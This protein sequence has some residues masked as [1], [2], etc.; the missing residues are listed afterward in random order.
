MFN[1]LTAS[2][3]YAADQLFATLDPTLRR[4]QVED[5]GPV[6]V[7]DTV[8]FIRHLPHKLVESFRAT[9]EEAVSSDLLVHVIDC[10]D[11][12]RDDHNRQ[13]HE[14][15]AEIGA[16]ELPMLEVY[17]KID[18]IGQPPRIERNGEGRPVRVWLSARRANGLELLMEALSELLVG[19]LVDTDVVLSPDKSRLRSRLFALGGVQ[20]EEY[21]E[22]GCTCLLYTSD[23]ADE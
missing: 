8:G 7:A 6:V 22:Q 16:D 9:L 23:A 20:Q 2:H 14:V 21:N 17:N 18:L 4:L 15:L 19:D 3:V 11:E 13:V 10:A 5:V 12:E 1:S